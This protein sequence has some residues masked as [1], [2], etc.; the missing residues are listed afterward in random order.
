MRLTIDQRT[1]FAARTV[2][3]L[4]T[5]KATDTKVRYGKFVKMIGLRPEDGD[6]DIEYRRLGDQI[7]DSVSSMECQDGGEERLDYDRIVDRDGNPC[8]GAS[9]HRSRIVSVA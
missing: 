6:W 5:L 2:T 8:R 7:L 9:N 1:A 4:K 3:V